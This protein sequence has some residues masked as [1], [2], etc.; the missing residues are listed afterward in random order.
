MLILPGSNA[1]SAFRAQRLLTQ[2]QSIDPAIA[3]VS[4]RT[5]HFV[6]APTALTQQDLDRL[7]AL[8]TYGEPF[9]GSEDGEEFVVV[10][11]FGTISPW[12]SKATDIARN[13]GMT[14]VHRIERGVS[15]R[16]RRKAG[17]FG[18]A[19]TIAAESLPAVV[20]L[21]HDRMTETVLRDPADAAALF[22]DIPGQPLQ[23]VDVLGGGREAL[24]RANAELGLAMSDDEIDYLLDA[25][26]RLERNPTDVELMMFA[27][28]NSEHCRHK[29]FNASWTIDGEPQDRSLFAMI[30]NTHALQPK[31]TVV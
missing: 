29:I 5:L 18:G 26:R 9:D 2:L 28:A 20:A 7:G 17:L 3:A 25:F 13:C 24:V 23:T 10:P 12:A 1:L 21:L 31:G 15:F 11:R 22:R 8:L 14:H 4:G 19:K 6:D 16:I 27:Q 30:R